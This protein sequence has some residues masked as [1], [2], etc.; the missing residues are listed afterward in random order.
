MVIGVVAV[1][2]TDG[3]LSLAIAH[4]GSSFIHLGVLHLAPF[5]AMLAIYALWSESNAQR[6]YLTVHALAA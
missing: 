5:I 6:C 1:L 4:P 2:D 3:N